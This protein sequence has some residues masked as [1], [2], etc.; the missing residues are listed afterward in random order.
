MLPTTSAVA[1][2]RPR[3]RG[4]A[5]AAIVAGVSFI[6]PREAMF[7]VERLQPRALRSSLVQQSRG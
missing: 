3:G 5:V 2:Q 1:D 4:V 6:S 7:F